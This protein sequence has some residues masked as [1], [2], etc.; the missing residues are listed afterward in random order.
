MPWNAEA[1]GGFTTGTPW[2]SFAPGRETANVA[3]QTGRADSLLSLYRTLIALRHQHAALRTGTLEIVDGLPSALL[4]YRR[5]APQ[6]KLLVLHNLDATR[7]LEVKAYLPRRATRLWPAAPAARKT[8]LAP[9]E[10]AIWT[11]R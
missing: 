7:T 4:G 8:R 2:F 9:G 1:G 5:L 3:A 6:Q 10:T 11:L